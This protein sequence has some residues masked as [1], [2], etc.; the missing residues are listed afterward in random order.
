MIAYP[1]D[2][3][4]Q[5]ASA[6]TAVEP[7]TANS[8]SVVGSTRCSSPTSAHWAIQRPPSAASSTV[9]G[10]SARCGDPRRMRSTL[11]CIVAASSAGPSATV[12]T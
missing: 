9:A 11:A 7:N 3:S 10:Y 4:S 6:T 1:R 2:G 5:A 12:S 8:V